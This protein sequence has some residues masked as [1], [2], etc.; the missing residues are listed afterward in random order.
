V[1]VFVAGASGAIGRPLVRRLI[2]AGHEVTGMTRRRER[3]D[4][5]EAA[6]ASAVVCDVYDAKALNAA[7]LRAKPE[8]LVHQLTSLPWELDPRKPETYAATNR[9]RTEGTRNLIEAARAA[10]ARRLVAQSIATLY[11][12][13]GGWVKSEEDPVLEGVPGHFGEAMNAILDLER[14]V[15]QAEGLEGLALRYGFFYGPHTQYAP[16]GYWAQEVRRRRF[17]VVGKGEGMLS[18]IQVEDA[19]GA[20]V[21]ACERGAPGVYNVVDDEPARLRDWLPAYA[22]ALGAKRPLRVPI[23]LAKLV[24]GRQIIAMATSTRGASNAKAKRE[25]GWE[26]LYSSWR[27]GFREALG[28]QPPDGGH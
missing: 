26:P 10:G 4:E 24:A 23:W 2:A 22:E 13:V 7:I 17:P 28:R 8:V 3:A 9:V 21:A 25:L 14:Q 16:D 6:G 1:R 12:P 18:F 20:T 15:T 19:A 27:L 5:I 11:A